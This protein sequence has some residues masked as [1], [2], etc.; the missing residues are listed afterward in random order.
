VGDTGIG[1]YRQKKRLRQADVA[2][3]LGTD[4]GRMSRI[5]SGSEI[6]T[7]DEVDKLV[8]LLEVPPGYL[9]D[10]DILS[11]IAKKAAAAS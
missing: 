8:A 1:Y 6:P 11:H 3:V 4:T 5:E 2:N 9:F 7:A 10:K